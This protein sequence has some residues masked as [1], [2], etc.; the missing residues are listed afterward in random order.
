[1]TQLD[2]QNEF[3]GEERLQSNYRVDISTVIYWF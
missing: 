3:L 2:D 1:M